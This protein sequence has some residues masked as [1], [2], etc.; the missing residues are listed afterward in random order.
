MKKTASIVLGVLLLSNFS[1]A[2]DITLD[3]A[4]NLAIENDSSIIML[5]A[6]KRQ[7]EREYN[8]IKK[9]TRIWQ[10]KQGYSFQTADEYFL[11]TGDAL[12][13][14]QLKYDVYLKSIENAKNKIEYNLLSSLYNLQLAEKNIALLEKNVEI[15]EKQKL[16]HELKYKLNMISQVDLDNFILNYNETKNTLENAKNQY[17]LGK[18]NIKIMLGQTEEVTVIL[19]ESEVKELIIEDIDK[20]ISEN[21]N[22]NKNILELNYNYKKLENQHIMMKKSLYTDE[23]EMMIDNINLQKKVV[24]DNYKALGTQVKLLTSNMSTMYKSY[25]NNIKSSELDI[26]TKYNQLELSKANMK[27]IEARYKEGYIA[28]LDYQAAKLGVEQSEISYKKAVI[29]NILLNAEFERFIETGF[30]KVQ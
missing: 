19:P 6:E 8:D 5:N 22:N 14:A 29:D 3:E 17:N 21:I 30:T 25:Y 1:F 12:K 16:V 2:K 13:E 18:E 20:F 26:K 4:I 11:Y 10:N 27:V 7:Q 9:D 15:L 24:E 28:E 23:Y